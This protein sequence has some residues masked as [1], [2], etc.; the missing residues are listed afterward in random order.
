V[1]FRRLER[2]EVAILIF[3]EQT[4]DRLAKVL[5]HPVAQLRWSTIALSEAARSRVVSLSKA[6]FQGSQPHCRRCIVFDILTTF[7]LPLTLDV[8]W[9]A[10][11]EER[12]CA[13]CLRP[14]RP[15]DDLQFSDGCARVFGHPR[16]SLEDPRVEDQWHMP[17]P[18]SEKTDEEWSAALN[19][20]ETDGQDFV[21][22]LVWNSP[23]EVHFAPD[24]VS[25]FAEP[26]EFGNTNFT[27]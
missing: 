23:P 6:S 16:K 5:E 20:V 25:R 3:G 27:G 13:R 15:L 11:V 22:I 24:N 10:E 26:A 1:V 17:V 12:P 4:I 8:G 2:E 18:F 14:Q 19:F 7:F 9:I 21:A